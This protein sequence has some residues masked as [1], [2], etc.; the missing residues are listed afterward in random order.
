MISISRGGLPGWNHVIFYV[1]AVASKVF[2]VL[3]LHCKP[4]MHYRR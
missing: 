1:T 4:E 2:L 3:T